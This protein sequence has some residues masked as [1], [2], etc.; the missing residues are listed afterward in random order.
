MRESYQYETIVCV[1]PWYMGT[2]SDTGE[3]IPLVPPFG[4]GYIVSIFDQSKRE[5]QKFA[6]IWASD[7]YD[8]FGPGM[9][10]MGLLGLMF[11]SPMPLPVG[12]SGTSRGIN[13]ETQARLLQMID[14][15]V[16]F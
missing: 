9:G 7:L 15:S 8:A 2:D 5:A 4:S 16:R 12:S 3:K 14:P 6:W 11:G 10:Q 1:I 13:G